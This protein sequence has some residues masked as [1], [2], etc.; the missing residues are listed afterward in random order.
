MTVRSYI[1]ADTST[2]VLNVLAGPVHSM[3]V[4]TRGPI[5]LH[6]LTKA[7]VL[8]F[9]YFVHVQG[10]MFVSDAMMI[11]SCSVGGS[12]KQ[13]DL[14][15]IPRLHG[16]SWVGPSWP[17]AGTST[18]RHS[19]SQFGAGT[20]PFGKSVDMVDWCTQVMEGDSYFQSVNYNVIEIQP[21]PSMSSCTVI[22]S[23][24]LEEVK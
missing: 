4:C 15:N 2:S 1:C 20:S 9:A 14:N 22:F 21:S 7:L 23:R 18:G 24:C 3:H 10:A 13:S 19:I 12:T 17:L 11:P 8:R 6:T 5:R 16:S